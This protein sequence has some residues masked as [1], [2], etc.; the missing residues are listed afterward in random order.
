VIQHIDHTQRV[1]LPVS[2]LG[3][4]LQ[5]ISAADLIQVDEL[6]RLLDNFD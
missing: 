6:V 2:R 3:Y 4:L 5:I 1:V